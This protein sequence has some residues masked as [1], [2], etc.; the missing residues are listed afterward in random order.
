MGTLLQTLENWIPKH[1]LALLLAA[2]FPVWGL[3][4]WSFGNS[5]SPIGL[6]GAI[7]L[8]LPLG[9]LNNLLTIEHSRISSLLILSVLGFVIGWIIVPLW[10]WKIW[11]R[12]L[13]VAVVI[14]NSCG[15][16]Y[17]ALSQ[18]D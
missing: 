18:M 8:L 16:I 3:V 4:I 13:I 17:Y 7:C 1:W 15:Y 11:M 2:I 12:V 5:G 10:K 14:L 6:F 9:Y